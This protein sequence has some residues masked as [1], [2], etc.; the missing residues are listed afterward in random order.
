MTVL[1]VE[2]EDAVRHLMRRVLTA[3]GYRV[4][5]A[6]DG[7]DALAVWRRHGDEIDVLLTDVVMPRM[8]GPELVDR[9]RSERPDLP[10]VVCSGYS[11][12][13]PT[14]V[15]SNDPRTRYLSKPFSLPALS[16]A[17]AMVSA[18][19]RVPV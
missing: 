1:V 4:I 13:L 19:A 10:V 18:V 8:T 6:T 12:T 3:A 7:E 16:D 15:P 17:V 14:E 9:L 11:D 2:D 5:M